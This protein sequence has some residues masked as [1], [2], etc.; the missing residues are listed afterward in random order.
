MALRLTV[1]LFT[2]NQES[3]VAQALDSILMQEFEGEYEIVVADDCSTDR[4]QEILRK[5]QQRHPDIIRLEFAE[6]N[7]NDNLVMVQ[8]FEAAAGEYIALLEG[9]DFW[10]SPTKLQKQLQFLDNHPECGMCFHNVAHLYEHGERRKGS[11]AFHNP[12]GQREFITLDNVLEGSFIAFGSMVC[13]SGLIGCFPDWYRSVFAADWA[14]SILYAKCATV[15]YIDEVMGTYRIHSNGVWSRLDAIG[16]LER[17]IKTEEEMDVNFE[18]R[19]HTKSK[20]NIAYCNF[21]LALAH[22]REFNFSASARCLMKSIVERPLRGW[23][24][25][26]EMALAW[27][28]FKS[29]LGSRL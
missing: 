6:K 28:L 29:R 11:Q 19:Y 13:R 15:G 14:L 10:T 16:K 17:M 18:R 20:R 9:D 25:L 27:K 23:I 4:T 26:R 7:L 8:L 22:A 1:L 21:F 24:P 12:Q 3:Y 2:Y 5:Y